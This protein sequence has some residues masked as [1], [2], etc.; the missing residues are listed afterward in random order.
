MGLEGPVAR[1]ERMARY[2]AIG[3]RVPGLQEATGE[4]V[5]VSTEDVRSFGAKIVT[6]GAAALA[7]YGP[8]ADAP[9]LQ[10]LKE[11]LAA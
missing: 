7:L 4:I 6:E 8:V 10:A 1:T 3:G 5:G 2:L 11:R 9:G